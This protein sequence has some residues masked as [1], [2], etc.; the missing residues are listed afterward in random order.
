[1]TMKPTIAN[2]PLPVWKDLYSAAA[3]F[4]ALQPWEVLDDMDLIGVRDPKS[5][6]TGYGVVMGSGGTLFGFCL[7]RGA[8]GFD[9]YRQLIVGESDPESGDFFAVQNCLKVEFGP[10]SDLS[11]EDLAVIQQLGLTF[12]GKHAWPEF[13]S[14]LP[15]YFPWFLTEAEARF[16]TLALE[17]AC[18]HCDQ[19]EQG[20]VDESFR[21]NECLVY[22][23]AT[24]PSKQF[25]A[26]W[27]P[28]PQCSHAAVPLPVLDLARINAILVKKPK[29]DSP[30]EADVF[31]LPSTIHDRDRPYFV[32]MAAVCQQASGFAFAA[33][34][35]LPET[36]L[37]PALADTICASIER[38]GLLPEIIFVK[39]KEEA[40]ALT[41]IGKALG[42]T[43]RY[44]KNLKT[45]QFLKEE[46]ERHMTHGGRRP[47]R[48]PR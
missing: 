3:K 25:N 30:W 28:W 37:V 24:E 18:H 45:I 16:L 4:Q 20:E 15:G 48:T 38:H 39:R 41:P 47:G 29:P 46:M 31:Y 2:V 1:M 35:I 36:S 44:R 27:E 9:M 12:K 26:R 34:I 17:A 10:R 5:A 19:V 21:D 7:Y 13:R 14:L 8:E 32:R 6:E 40:T 43:I 22:S 42:I 11:P 23:P 33:D